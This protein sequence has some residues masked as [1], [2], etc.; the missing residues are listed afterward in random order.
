MLVVHWLC[1]AGSEAGRKCLRFS[2]ITPAINASAPFDFGI[3]FDVLADCGS[4]LCYP[5]LE[6]QVALKLLR[7][8]LEKA[9]AMVPKP[10]NII[11]LGSGTAVTVMTLDIA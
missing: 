2:R 9:K 5:L 1:P 6:L 7:R 4:S 8:R 10:S 11:E 3:P